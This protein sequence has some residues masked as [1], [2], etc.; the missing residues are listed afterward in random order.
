MV[1]T[2]SAK[3]YEVY[4]NGNLFIKGNREVTINEER[5]YI[6]LSGIVRP[7]DISPA[8]EVVSSVIADAKISIS[9]KGVISDKQHPGNGHRLFD[10][11]WPF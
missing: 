3:V 4:P 6:K 9:G 5:Q 7:E 11:L 10:F 8:N 1:A 2:I